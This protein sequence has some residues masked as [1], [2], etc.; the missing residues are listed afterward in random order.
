[1]GDEYKIV[2]VWGLKAGSANVV[3]TA[4]DR[5]ETIPCKVKKGTQLI[6]HDEFSLSKKEAAASELDDYTNF[7][8]WQINEYKNTGKTYYLSFD[9]K[10]DIAAKRNRG[11][12]IGS[13]WNK[14]MSSSAYGDAASMT[15]DT[16][17]D[18]SAIFTT[19]YIDSETGLHFC[20]AFVYKSSKSGKEK[21][22][23]IIWECYIPAQ[24]A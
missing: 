7:I 9:A 2:T 10:G 18:E 11:I 3:I 15:Y 14:V 8:D 13:T 19:E 23:K 12:T 22:T 6:T 5:E 1:M 21:V 17:Q 16:W 4:G 24:T 20:K